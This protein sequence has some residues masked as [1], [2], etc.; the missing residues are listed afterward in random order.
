MGGCWFYMSGGFYGVSVDVARAIARCSYASDNKYGPE[1]AV[2]GSWMHA[3]FPSVSTVEVPFGFVHYHFVLDKWDMASKIKE[4]RIGTGRRFWARREDSASQLPFACT[5]NHVCFQRMGNQDPCG[6]LQNR[7]ILFCGDSFIRHAYEGMALVLSGD[8]SHGAIPNDT[9]CADEAQFD[10]KTC[11]HRV[12]G[13]IDTACGVRLALKYSSWCEV[14]N[15]GGEYDWI[16]WGFGAHP[17]DDDYVT[18]R[19][20]YDAEVVKTERLG[21]ICG[22]VDFQSS[23]APRIIILTNHRHVRDD[24]VVATEFPDSINDRILQFTRGI[25]WPLRQMCGITRFVDTFAMTDALVRMEPEPRK[26]SSDGMHWG[27]LVNIAKAWMLI[28]HIENLQRPFVKQGHPVVSVYLSG[29]LGNQLFQA[30]SSFGI[31]VSRGAQWCIPYLEASVLQQ[32]VVFD[33]EPLACVSEGVQVADENGNFLGF[34]QWM[35]HG[36]QSIR[37]GTY[38][39][40]YR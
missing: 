25:H 8:Y 32:S 15:D 24:A 12:P 37:V 33:V 23:L 4:R 29:G 36:D 14:E 3:C 22:V 26:L 21:R 38:L 11:R 6:I 34:Q 9:F 16:V 18:R 2:T 19:G 10:E 28:D 40:S 5:S 13:Q 20:V 35:M 27:R 17:L 1:D 31:A 39:Q 7:S 30:A